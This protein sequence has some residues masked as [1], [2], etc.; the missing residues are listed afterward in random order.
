MRLDNYLKDKYPE[1]TRSQIQDLIKRSLVLVNEKVTTKTGYEVKNT[2]EINLLDTTKYVSR[3]GYKLENA[4]KK[5]KISF[6]KI[7]VMDVGS[8]TGGFTDFSIQNGADLV[9]AYDVGTDQ[10]VAKLRNNEKVK[11]FEKTNILSINPPNA[12]II[13]I[14][15][16]FTSSKP[17][18]KHLKNN[19]NQILLLIKPQFEVGPKHLSKGIVKDKKRVEALL[20]EFELLAKELEF[21][22]IDIF[23][24]GFPGKDGNLEYW[25][26]L[27]K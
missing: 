27:V 15:V 12:D 25:L 9:Y 11:L 20:D 23:E 10:M 18:L 17:I 14:D 4:V 8:S 3:A 6:S 2:D 21:Q 5:L 19:S 16:S 13:L 7:V 26:Y 24:S 1:Y 22:V